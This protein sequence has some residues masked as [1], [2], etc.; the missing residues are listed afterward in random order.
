[1]P[2]VA[3]QQGLGPDSAIWHDGMSVALTLQN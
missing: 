3:K 2:I 1:M